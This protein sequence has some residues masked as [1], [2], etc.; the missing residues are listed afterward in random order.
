MGTKLMNIET[1]AECA[2]QKLLP[3]LPHSLPSGK[4]G[5]LIVTLM[6]NGH[7]S[8]WFPADRLVWMLSDADANEDVDRFDRYAAIGMA[9]RTA[10]DNELVCA[11]HFRTDHYPQF[12]GKSV[13]LMAQ[14]A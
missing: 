3:S 5:A 6:Q 1:L 4:H 12:D 7:I 2:V 9:L 13:V 11:V 14:K 8:Q 10:Q